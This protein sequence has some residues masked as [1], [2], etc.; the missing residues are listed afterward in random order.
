MIDLHKILPLRWFFPLIAVLPVFFVACLAGVFL[1]VSISNQLD[2]QLE[3]NLRGLGENISNSSE[4]ALQTKNT[5]ELN[6]LICAGLHLSAEINEIEIL[7]DRSVQVGDCRR[8]VKIEGESMTVTLPIHPLDRDQVKSSKNIVIGYVRINSAKSIIENEKRQIRLKIL[9]IFTITVFFTLLFSYFFTRKLAGAVI[10]L[11]QASKSITDKNFQIDFSKI[12]GGEVGQMQKSFLDMSRTMSDFTKQLNNNVEARTKELDTQKNLLEKAYTEN[13]RLIHRINTAI[14]N[15]RRVIALD[16]HDVFNTVI[17]HI[18]GTA[19][20]TK[21]MLRKLDQQLDLTDA[22]SNLVAIEQNANHLYALSKDLVSNLRPEVLDEFGLAEA[23]NDLV[24]KNRK[25][26][27]DCQYSLAFNA[28]I[29]R[30]DYDFNIAIYRIVQESLSNVAKHANATHCKITLTAIDKIDHCRIVLSIIDDGNGF[31]M[32]NRKQGF[33][34]EGMRER[35]GGIGGTIEVSSAPGVGT[36]I[37]LSVD[38][39]NQSQTEI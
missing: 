4:F 15:E 5:S 1:D 10:E 19:R 37:L 18:L 2:N 26:H 29:P 24:D 21:S 14:E 25:S 3:K 34:L 36:N 30:F 39:K 13:K 7:D 23:L 31:D 27:A 38:K 35:A 12:L 17:L 33:G 6:K 20:Q 28:Q 9:G 22:Q 32:S 11:S 16:L 8:M